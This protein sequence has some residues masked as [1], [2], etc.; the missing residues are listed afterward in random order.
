MQL[1]KLHV[2]SS[3]TYGTIF[4]KLAYPQYSEISSQLMYNN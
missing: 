4:T 2:N 3:Y 1:I